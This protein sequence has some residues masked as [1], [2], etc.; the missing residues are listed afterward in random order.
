M[1]KL[2]LGDIWADK[3]CMVSILGMSSIIEEPIVYVI[4][5]ISG[6]LMEWPLEYFNDMGL[7]FRRNFVNKLD[8][9]F[10]LVYNEYVPQEWGL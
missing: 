10:R 4:Y 9:H 1:N 3:D 6:G 2:E 5:L 7:V 8:T